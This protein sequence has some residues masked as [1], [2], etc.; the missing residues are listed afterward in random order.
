ME[1]NI[2]KKGH[3]FIAFLKDISAGPFGITQELMSFI[4]K[5]E[6]FKGAE[7]KLRLIDYKFN[8]PNQNLRESTDFNPPKSHDFFSNLQAGCSLGQW[9]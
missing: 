7:K 6:L 5:D 4:A 2:V 9:L 3:E 8:H 1:I